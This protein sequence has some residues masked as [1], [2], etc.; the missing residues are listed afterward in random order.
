[1]IS[2]F[3]RVDGFAPNPSAKMHRVPGRWEWLATL[4]PQPRHQ[5]WHRRAWFLHP[6]EWVCVD[7][8]EVHDTRL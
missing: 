4:N 6:Q 3:S 1:M 5:A 7:T 2:G 8:G